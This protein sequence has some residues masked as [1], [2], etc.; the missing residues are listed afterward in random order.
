MMDDFRRYICK[1][2]GVQLANSTNLYRDNTYEVIFTSGASEANCMIIRGVTDSYFDITGK[3]PHIV[4]SSIEHKSLLEMIEMLVHRGQ[5]TATLINPSSSGHIKPADVGAAI[6]PTTCLICIMHANNETGAINDIKNIGLLAHNNNIPYHCDAVQA[7]GKI[8][9]NPMR[10]NV[11]SFCISSHKFQ[12]PP[13]TGAIVIKRKLLDMY[14]ISPMIF[15]TQNNGLRGGTENLPGI[16]ASFTAM[17]LAMESRPAKNAKLTRIKTFMMRE[18]SRRIPTRRFAEY[19]ASNRPK[20]PEIEIVFLSDNTEHYLPNTILLSI[21]KRSRPLIC[22]QK[23]KTELEKKGI[24]VSVGSACNTASPNAS[25]VLY[26]MKADELIRKGA[27]RISLGDDNSLDEA[28]KFIMEFLLI[29][30]KYSE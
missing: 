19:L 17:R 28:K 23:I 14:K 24:I 2:C 26:A 15:G 13:G 1:L 25:H 12:G 7:F 29:L 21:V 16:G 4:I 3:K 5:I 10:D 30:E 27:L 6:T 20:L 11:D 9:L 18:L 8:P 22:N